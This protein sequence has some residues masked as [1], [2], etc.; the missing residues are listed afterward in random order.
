MEFTPAAP[1]RRKSQDSLVQ[2]AA[3]AAFAYALL[4]LVPTSCAF[5]SSSHP[6]VRVV[7]VS[8]G[9]GHSLALK[10]NGSVWAWGGD[11]S[12]QLGNGSLN[13]TAIPIAV[14]SLRS[15]VVAIAAGLNHSL[16]L[17][18]DGS[19]WA[20]GNNERGQLGNGTTTG[21][22]VPLAVSGLTGRVV[23]I[24]AGDSDAGYGFGNPADV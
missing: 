10:S 17:K 12:G 14:S 24:A 23:A 11:T 6:A 21:S 22:N 4:A 2:L 18:S 1:L 15:G 19:V 8:A 3:Y 20:W 16:A 7:A 5:G 13:D 9:G